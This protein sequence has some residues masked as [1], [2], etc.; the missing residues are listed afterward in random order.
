MSS[1]QYNMREAIKYYFSSNPERYETWQA[2][3][4]HRIE[5]FALDKVEIKMYGFV[6][7]VSCDIKVVENLTGMDIYIQEVICLLQRCEIH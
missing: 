5:T 7:Q 1:F 6:E 3:N 4:N 2:V